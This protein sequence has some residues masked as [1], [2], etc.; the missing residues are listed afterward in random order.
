MK[1]GGGGSGTHPHPLADAACQQDKADAAIGHGGSVLL[2]ARHCGE[3]SLQ[4]QGQGARRRASGGSGGQ[5]PAAA[6]FS[7]PR[8]TCAAAWHTMVALR[9]AADCLAACR[10]CCRPCTAGPLH[11][12]CGRT[13]RRADA[14]A[15]VTPC[16]VFTPLNAARAA[17]IASRSD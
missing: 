7:R 17:A 5:R 1:G 13:A 8:R 9:T 11:P 2:Q 12:A 16:L 6:V 10:S 15:G 3:R 14:G 4:R